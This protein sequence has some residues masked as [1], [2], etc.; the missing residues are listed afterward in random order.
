MEE[1]NL[2]DTLDAILNDSPP[3][4]LTSVNSN[5]YTCTADKCELNIEEV[6]SSFKIVDM[7]IDSDGS[8]SDKYRSGDEEGSNADAEK[9]DKSA[10]I[11]TGLTTGDFY[12]LK[13][14]FCMGI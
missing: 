8:T 10:R 14:A 6:D 3:P 12:F 1:L 2:S 4:K 11:E 13:I 5:N 9:T 7:R